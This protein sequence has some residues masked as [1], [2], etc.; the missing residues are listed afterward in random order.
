M[1]SSVTVRRIG[2]VPARTSSQ[3]W[4]AI[5]DL[6]ADPHSTAHAKLLQ[7]TGVASMLIAEA[8]TQGAPIVVTPFAGA[9]VRIYTVHGDTADEALSDEMRLAAW[10]TA[11]AGWA[12]SLPCGEADLVF[13]IGAL[14][15]LPEITVRDVALSLDAD[16]GAPDAGSVTADRA[17]GLR[18]DTSWLE[19]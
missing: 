19:D 10:P 13:A 1:S 5:A 14:A 3:T 12:V 4:R 2:S 8:Y 17:F 16:N 11:V 7:C 6:L 9:R 15:H 18:V